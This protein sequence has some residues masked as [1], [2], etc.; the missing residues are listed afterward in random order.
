MA[1][2][3]SAR[4]ASWM[5]L[6]FALLIPHCYAQEDRRVGAFVS[7][8]VERLQLLRTQPPTYAE[9][10]AA[11]EVGDQ[12]LGFS[13]ASL[14]ATSPA[15]S[16][17]GLITGYYT[18]AG[19][20]IEALVLFFSGTAQAG[21]SL[22][23]GETPGQI[24][25][26]YQGDIFTLENFSQIVAEG[27]ISAHGSVV[28][29]SKIIA[30]PAS[31]PDDLFRDTEWKDQ[32]SFSVRASA[33]ERAL[34]RVVLGLPLAVISWGVYQGRLELI[35]RTGADTAS[36]TPYAIAA[37][38]AIALCAGFVIDSAV[39]IIQVLSVAK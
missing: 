34:G 24:V 8:N 11:S 16:E 4:V 23:Y 17:N 7:V 3:R 30:S 9:Y 28:K 36:A 12:A 35:A 18:V 5:L 22:D 25:S 1:R 38:S 21:G 39:K 14:I 2:Q 15:V 27:K 19:T 6:W 10:R 26:Y 20:K 33:L 31:L 13:L 37:G 29:N 32:D